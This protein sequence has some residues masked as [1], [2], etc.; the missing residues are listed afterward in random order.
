[1]IGQVRKPVDFAEIL[2]TYSNPLTADEFNSMEICPLDDDHDRP[3]DDDHEPYMVIVDEDR[4]SYI[5]ED[6]KVS[7]CYCVGGAL[8]DYYLEKNIDAC[9]I[10]NVMDAYPDE[11]TWRFPQARQLADSL[12]LIFTYITDGSHELDV[13]FSV[14][15]AQQIIDANDRRE[16]DQAWQIVEGLYNSQVFDMLFESYECERQAGYEKVYWEE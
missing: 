9:P 8:V 3:L 10:T 5:N 4:Q 13:G 2:Q 7:K 14:W 16:F 15:L 11:K 1:M 6:G 12:R